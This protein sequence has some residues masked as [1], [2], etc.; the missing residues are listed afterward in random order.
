MSIRAHSFEEVFL[1]E[2]AFGLWQYGKNKN[3]DSIIIILLHFLDFIGSIHIIL[4][5]HIWLRKVSFSLVPSYVDVIP[6]QLF[7][8][9]SNRKELRFF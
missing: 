4:V 8:C 2:K 6:Y 3:V 7:P 1:G 9:F 5:G